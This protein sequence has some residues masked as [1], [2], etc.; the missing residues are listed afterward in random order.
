MFPQQMSSVREVL[1]GRE[2][3]IPDTMKK[4]NPFGIPEENFTQELLSKPMPVRKSRSTTVLPESVRLSPKEI[5]Y[6]RN[7]LFCS[8]IGDVR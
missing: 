6:C 5:C 7:R 2:Y 4:E 3:F 1:P 8:G